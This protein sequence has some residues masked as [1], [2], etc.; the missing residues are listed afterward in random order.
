MLDCMTCGHYCIPLNR[1][2][3]EECVFVKD[4]NIKAESMKINKHFV[5][6]ARQNSNLC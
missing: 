1:N 3:L 5:T 4:K 6:L 2:K